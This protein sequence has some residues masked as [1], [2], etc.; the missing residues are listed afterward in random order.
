MYNPT[1]LDHFENPRNVGEMPDATA[2]AEVTNPACGD[3]LKLW[4]RV[5][6]GKVAD[7]KFKVS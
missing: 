5:E 7:V 1:I 6:N 3:I 2:V 4:V